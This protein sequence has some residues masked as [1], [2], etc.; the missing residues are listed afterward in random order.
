MRERF[1]KTATRPMN[2]RFLKTAAR[3]MCGRFP[4][5]EILRTIGVTQSGAFYDPQSCHDLN[6]SY[7]QTP[8]H[9]LEQI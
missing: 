2:G 1:L 6:A 9:F 4:K 8:N 3:P 7:R 5:T